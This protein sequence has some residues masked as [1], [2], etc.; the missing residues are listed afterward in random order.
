MPDPLACT[1]FPLG[2]LG[3][4]LAAGGQGLAGGSAGAWLGGPVAVADDVVPQGFPSGLPGPVGWQLQ[5]RF[6]GWGAKR[7]GTLIR[8]RRKVAGYARS[9]RRPAR[10]SWR[11]TAQTGYGPAARRSNRRRWSRRWR[12]GGG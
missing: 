10:R 3:S 4:G 7:A 6:A 2:F 12:G 5:H 11:R 1:S 8:S 9:P